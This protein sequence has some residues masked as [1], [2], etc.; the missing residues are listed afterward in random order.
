MVGVYKKM[1]IIIACI[2]ID[3]WA[4]WKTARKRCCWLSSAR[5]ASQRAN[6][7]TRPFLVFTLA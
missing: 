6:E 3:T 7:C 2:S 1:W 4:L 5:R